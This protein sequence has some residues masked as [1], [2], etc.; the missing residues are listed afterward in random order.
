M[1]VGVAVKVGAG[2]NLCVG[3]GVA[4]DVGVAVGDGSGVKAARS[5][6]AGA[7]VSV[8]AGAAVCLPVLQAPS[9]S[10]RISVV[11]MMGLCMLCSLLDRKFHQIIN[12]NQ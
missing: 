4:V 3:I 11:K 10:A 12:D 5:V 2:V 8:A 9:S 7:W 6:A 1:G